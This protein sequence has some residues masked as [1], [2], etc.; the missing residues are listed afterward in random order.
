MPLCL[1][2]SLPYLRMAFSV[3]RHILNRFIKIVIKIFTSIWINYFLV[4]DQ[5]MMGFA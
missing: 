5:K 2:G 3:K 4:E 1:V